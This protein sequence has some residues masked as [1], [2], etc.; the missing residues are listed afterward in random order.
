M[1]EETKMVLNLRKQELFVMK[2]E[3]FR[4]NFRFSKDLVLN[5]I[6]VLEPRLQPKTQ[7]DVK[8]NVHH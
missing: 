5:V 7:Y 4:K 2:D 6:S 1:F 3:A 8:A